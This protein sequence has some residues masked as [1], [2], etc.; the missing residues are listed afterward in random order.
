MLLIVP[1]FARRLPS[2]ARAFHR[3]ASEPS[4]PATAAATNGDVPAVR[5]PS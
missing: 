3:A 4:T 1:V 2:A 5:T